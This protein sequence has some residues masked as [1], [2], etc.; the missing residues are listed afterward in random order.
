MSAG[1]TAN[2]NLSRIFPDTVRAQLEAKRSR[3]RR[4]T[5]AQII[6]PHKI[7]GL[8]SIRRGLIMHRHILAAL[9]TQP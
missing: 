5:S 2:Q 7:I 9:S 6:D 4:P 8:T 3:K 1:K